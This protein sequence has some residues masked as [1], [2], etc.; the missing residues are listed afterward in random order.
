MK[1]GLKIWSTNDFYIE[2]IKKLYK[3][4]VFDYLELFVVPGSLKYIDIWKDLNI[5]I[6]LHA[7][8]Y[9]VGFNFSDKSKEKDNKDLLGLVKEYNDYLKPI[10][11]IF[12]PGIN[13]TIDETIRQ[14]K[15]FKSEFIEIFN[16]ALIENKPSLGL[17]N[18]I[19]IGDSPDAISKIIENTNIGFCLD[20]GHAICYS[21]SN[22]LKWDSVLKEFNTL[23]PTIYHISDGD[24]SNKKDQH[25]NLG[26]GN[27]DFKKI[28]RVLKLHNAWISIETEKNSLN[29]LDNF[30]MDAFFLQK[31]IS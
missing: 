21:A 2:P 8:H 4:K 31:S 26:K 6:I 28:F 3:S 25:L 13:G 1:I 22:E 30:K 15:L 23:N 11:I 10:K 19:C 12:H 16:I 27:Y 20:I 9:A 14:I 29:N 18:E 24:M 5:P 17:N 7:P